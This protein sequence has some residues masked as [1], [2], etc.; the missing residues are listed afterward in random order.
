MKYK[1]ILSVFPL[2]A[3]AA[4]LV[5]MVSANI[6]VMIWWRLKYKTQGWEIV[7]S[8]VLLN[9]NRTYLKDFYLRGPG[10]LIISISLFLAIV[11]EHSLRYFL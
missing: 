9:T 4:V 10:F 1:E 7:Y 5:L 11:T 8:I 2:E 3:I 6:G